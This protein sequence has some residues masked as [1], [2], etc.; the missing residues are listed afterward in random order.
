MTTELF[1]QIKEKPTIRPT[2]IRVYAYG[3]NT[4]L[5]SVGM[6]HAKISHQDQ[7]VNAKIY[8]TQKGT[9]MLLSCHT[10][11]DLLQVTF[12]L[13]VHMSTVD[14]IIEEF[15]HVFQGIGCLKD[16]AVSLHI[17]KFIQPGHYTYDQRWRRNS[18]NPHGYPPQQWPGSQSS[19]GR[20]V[21]ALT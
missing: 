20:R 7:T 5:P 16:K 18:R 3:T 14:T 10:A 8:V 15:D 19:Q 17:D 4:P 11:E 1:D 21:S 9:G 13:S 6:F 2:C 12:A